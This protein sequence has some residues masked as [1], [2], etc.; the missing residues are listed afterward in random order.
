MRIV[1][2]SQSVFTK[3]PWSSH[4]MVLDHGAIK[5]KRRHTNIPR[6]ETGDHSLSSQQAGSVK[7]Y[8][9]GTWCLN[10]VGSTSMQR[11]DVASTL[12]RRCINVVCLLGNAS[13]IRIKTPPLTVKQHKITIIYVLS[14]Q[15]HNKNVSED[16][17]EVPQSRSTASR[18]TKK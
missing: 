8:P 13:Y 11:H 6:A 17:Q 12:R 16:T 7:E 1:D 3:I 5:S 10:N 4:L 18:F 15:Y 2:L 14:P 9:A